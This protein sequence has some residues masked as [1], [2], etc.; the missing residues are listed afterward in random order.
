MTP[1]THLG[2]QLVGEL[3][4]SVK[5]RSGPPWAHAWLAGCEQAGLVPVSESPAQLSP[6]SS[7]NTSATQVPSPY[8]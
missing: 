5:E 2:T 4:A 1:V 8:H 3:A 6:P 7:T